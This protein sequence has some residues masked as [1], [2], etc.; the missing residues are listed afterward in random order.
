MHFSIL[1]IIVALTASVS[2]SASCSNLGQ[3]CYETSDCCG[4]FFACKPAGNIVSTDRLFDTTPWL[5]L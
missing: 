2:V 3:Q 1:T 4:D 5:T